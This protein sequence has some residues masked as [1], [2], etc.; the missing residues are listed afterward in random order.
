MYLVEPSCVVNDSFGDSLGFEKTLHDAGFPTHGQ[1]LVD[2]KRVYRLPLPTAPHALLSTSRLVLARDHDILQQHQE[3][4]AKS[5]ACNWE[6]AI[7]T[8]GLV[9]S[10]S[11]GMAPPK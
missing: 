10:S 7:G 9:T 4:N 6:S 11:I 2:V 8:L 3:Y 1:R 5:S